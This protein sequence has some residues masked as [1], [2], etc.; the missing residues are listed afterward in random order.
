MGSSAPGQKQSEYSVLNEWPVAYQ[1]MVDNM[2]RLW[3]AMAAHMVGRG[4]GD[5]GGMHAMKVGLCEG[6]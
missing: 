6:V 2:S 5:E 3:E 4:I 1:K